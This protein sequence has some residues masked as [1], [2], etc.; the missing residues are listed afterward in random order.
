[1][2]VLVLLM[3]I[4]LMIVGLVAILESSVLIPEHTEVSN[5]IDDDD[6]VDDEDNDD[7]DN[8]DNPDIDRFIVAV[9]ESIS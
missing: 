4:V 9:V 3:L 2:A 5:S 1:M 7:E 6:D 8:D